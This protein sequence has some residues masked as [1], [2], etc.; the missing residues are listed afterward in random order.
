M[1]LDSPT[2]SLQIVLGEAKTTNDCDITSSYADSTGAFALGNENVKSNGV[3]IVTV[4]TAPGASVQRQVK[5]VRLTNNDT[6][7]HTVTFQLFD[8]T[9]TWAIGPLRQSIPAN[10][11]FVYTP[12]SGVVVITGGGGGSSLTLLDDSGHTIPSITS[13]QVLGVIASG[14]SPSG[15]VNMTTISGAAGV[16][17]TAGTGVLLTGGAPGG[18]V[19]LYGGAGNPT[20]QGGG[21]FAIAGY[22]T[23]GSGGDIAFSAGLGSTGGGAVRFLGGGGSSVST[24]GTITFTGGSGYGV[25]SGGGVYLTA[26][27]TGDAANATGITLQAASGGAT[28]GNGGVLQM[29]A[30]DAVGS[31]YGG[32]FR[33]QLGTGTNPNAGDGPGNLNI[34]SD[35]S[36]F[37]ITYSWVAGAQLNDQ[38][39]FT[40]TRALTVTAVIGRVDIVNGTAATLLAVKAASGT[41]PSGGTALTSTS[42]D[43]TGTANTNQTLTPSAT[44]T[45]FLLAPGDSICLVTTGTLAASAGCITV[46]GTPQ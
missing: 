2:K 27:V 9:N 1:N 20:Y 23:S 44:F 15:I 17:T 43:L 22:N 19:G 18:A 30:G 3:T 10:G 41:A 26:G 6:V 36:I 31:G 5:E 29:N 4:V 35:P 46:W 42:M 7:T 37:P 32:D 25:N 34:N 11:A 8:G 21:I 28:S 38:T 12:D 40:A 16:G 39:I 33:I 24:G 13:L 14:S 45:D